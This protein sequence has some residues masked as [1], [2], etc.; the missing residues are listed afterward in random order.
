MSTLFEMACDIARV[1]AAGHQSGRLG[2]EHEIEV[3]R[4]RIESL[5]SCLR[6]MVE[7]HDETESNT[8]GRYPCADH[9]C[10]D[11]TLGTVPNHLNTGRCAYH[12]ARK[13]LGIV[14]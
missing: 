2:A 8:E 11:C 7:E 13:L 1:H 9:G 4:A 5:E 6:G 10:I 14:S 3:L 12:K